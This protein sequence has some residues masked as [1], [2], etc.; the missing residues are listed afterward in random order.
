MVYYFII[1]SDGNRYGP[2]D[3]DTLV[4]WTREGR[5][6]SSTT[7]IERGTERQTTAGAITAIAAELRRL[8]GMQEPVAVERA[9]GPSHEAPT[10]TQAGPAARRATPVARGI[11]T[12][13]G[14]AP[15]PPVP[16]TLPYGR[17]Q[18]VSSRSRLVAGLLGI[19]LGGWGVHRFYLGYTGIG[20]LQIFLTLCTFGIAGLWGFIEGILCLTGNMRDVDGLAL[21]E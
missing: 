19:F 15:P 5:I 11:P 4:R 10:L 7:L 3:I 9:A 12:A 1:G 2:A 8:A 16:P 13:P 18:V 17:S 14:A 20:V 21:R 6:V